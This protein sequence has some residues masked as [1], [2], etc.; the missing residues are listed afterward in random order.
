[1]FSYCIQQKGLL[2]LDK[3]SILHVF[4][5]EIRFFFATASQEQYGDFFRGPRAMVNT[6]ELCTDVVLCA[7]CGKWREGEQERGRESE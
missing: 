2:W 4:E 5:I 6:L 7:A 3:L 1:M